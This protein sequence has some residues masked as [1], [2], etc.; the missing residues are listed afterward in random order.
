V[1]S[2]RHSCRRVLRVKGTGKPRISDVTPVV[3]RKI[4]REIVVL[5]GWGR[6]I[7]LQLAHPLVAAGVRDFSHFDQSAGGYI[8][9][10][11]ATV[12]G[13]LDITFGSSE[14]ACQAIARI[15]AIHQKVHGVLRQ[16]VGRWPA[17]T[18]YS[19]TDP[20]LLLWVHATLVDSMMLTYENLAGPLTPEERDRFCEESAQTGVLLGIP[21]ER[22][23][24]RAADLAAYMAG[25]YAG[26]ELTVGPDAQELARALFSPSFGP[27]TPLFRITRLITAGLLPASIRSGYGL[28]WSSR[29]ARVFRFLVALSRR[30]R[31]MIPTA[32]REWPIAREAHK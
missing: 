1:N 16:P 17:G 7:L 29:R 20:A 31:K 19:A 15:N 30:T 24:L 9:R 5:L 2:L 12:G 27:A 22:L 23:P 11:R 25:M 13:M 10:V 3:A 14:Q 8:R 4:N 18:P 26:G 32:V 21:P 6:A 28:P